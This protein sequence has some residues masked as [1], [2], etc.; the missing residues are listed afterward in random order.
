MWPAQVLPPNLSVG[1][2][3]IKACLSLGLCRVHFPGIQHTEAF[4][5]LPVIYVCM[6]RY[7]HGY[8]L[9]GTWEPCGSWNLYLEVFLGV[10]YMLPPLQDPP[11]MAT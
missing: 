5:Y 3:L 11:G 2:L 8:L 7:I 10:F 4:L 6:H 9:E 1:P